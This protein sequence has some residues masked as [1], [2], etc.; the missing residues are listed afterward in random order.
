MDKRNSWAR[1]SGND[2]ER[3]VRVNVVPG[4]RREKFQK[5]GDGI[6]LIHVREEAERGEANTRVRELIALHYGVSEKSVRIISGQRSHT[7]RL[8]IV[9]P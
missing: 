5:E 8:S 9:L 2:M 4:A 6:F 3:S 7:K 1:T